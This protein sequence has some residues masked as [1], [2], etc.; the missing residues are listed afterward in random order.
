VYTAPTG[1]FAQVMAVGGDGSALIGV[2]AA[3][4]CRGC[5]APLELGSVLLVS[6]TE[7]TGVKAPSGGW[8]SASAYVA[9]ALPGGGFILAVSRDNGTELVERILPDGASTV[10]T[11]PSAGRGDL[12]AGFIGVAA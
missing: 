3:P 9:S 6:P 1:D 5:S 2:G 10:A 12:D 11:V 7:E 8:A 4:A